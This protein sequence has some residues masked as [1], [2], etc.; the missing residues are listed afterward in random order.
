MNHIRKCPRC[1]SRMIPDGMEIKC[2]S[3]GYILPNQMKKHRFIMA[4]KEE[5]TKDYIATGMDVTHRKW[6]VCPSALYKLDSIREV[7]ISRPY[8]RRNGNH[9]C[10][11]T[12]PEF[13][14]EWTSDVQL[15]WLELYGVLLD[16]EVELEQ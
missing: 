12:L 11:P 10:L 4:N 14:C 15:K 2:L 8:R 1:S 5:I 16:K 3:C 6:N 13:S 7:M 9:N